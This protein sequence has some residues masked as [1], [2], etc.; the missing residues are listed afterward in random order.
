MWW[1]TRA[2]IDSSD[3]IAAIS[4]LKELGVLLL[5]LNICMGTFDQYGQHFTVRV[6][7]HAARLTGP[8]DVIAIKLG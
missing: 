7:S 2:T 6:P 8:L 4:I 1:R 3:S 5:L